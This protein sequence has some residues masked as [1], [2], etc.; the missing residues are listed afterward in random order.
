MG[1]QAFQQPGNQGFN[2]ATPNY[3]GQGG[4]PYNQ[5]Q[6][7]M[8]PYGQPQQPPQSNAFF[9]AGNQGFQQGQPQQR[10]PQQGYQNVNQSNPFAPP[11][12]SL[13]HDDIFGG[14]DAN[15]P[16]PGFGG[17]AQNPA[18]GGSGDGQFDDFINQLN[19]LRDL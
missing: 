8:T 7:G 15:T 4:N 13:G 16:K 14:Q 19:D 6:R 12:G 3:Q 18:N 1:N 11:G 10:P 9:N 5:G 17:P 2:N